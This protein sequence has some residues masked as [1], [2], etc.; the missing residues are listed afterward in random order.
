MI[1]D[2]LHG[3][4]RLEE[5]K[6]S[7]RRKMLGVVCAVAITAALFAGYAYMRKR[8][9]QQTLANARTPAATIDSM[10]KGPPMAN[11]A[12]DDPLL[13]K[14]MTVIGG[15]VTNI[16]QQD[17][18]SLTLSVELRRRKDG[19]IEETSIPVE[20]AN[21]KPQQHAV[22]SL[23]VPAQNYGSIRLVGLTVNPSATLIAYSSS[24]GKKR[25]PERLQPNVVITKPGSR[26]GEFINTPDNPVRVP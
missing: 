3:E 20:P 11:V 15:T 12:M 1:N 23:R 22:Y 14:G 8:H 16:S 10:P 17:L 2:P 26:G 21:L 9:A 19:G 5:Q 13:E 7:A 25:P 6:E 18:K 4:E 24:P